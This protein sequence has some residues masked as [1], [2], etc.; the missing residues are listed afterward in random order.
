M[1][2]SVPNISEE[3]S[4][5]IKPLFDFMWMKPNGA[6]ILTVQCSFYSKDGWQFC[7]NIPYHCIHVLNTAN[8]S[9]LSWWTT[10]F[11]LVHRIEA[12]HSV[13]S[14]A[15]FYCHVC[16]RAILWISPVS[17]LA[18]NRQQ[19]LCD[20]KQTDS[21]RCNGCNFVRQTSTVLYMLHLFPLNRAIQYL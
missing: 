15:Q 13:L 1:I 6:G 8:T 10:L 18:W 4:W 16:F 11:A 9:L 2:T 14:S 3:A 20:K 5:N 12:I 17:A 19:C 7:V 21:S